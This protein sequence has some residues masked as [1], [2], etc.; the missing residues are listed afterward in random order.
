M[1][2]TASISLTLSIVAFAMLLLVA[3]SPKSPSEKVA[4]ARG[5]YTAK[6]NGFYPKEE[7]APQ[8][9]VEGE[10]VTQGQEKGAQKA[11]QAGAKEAEK[12]SPA[13]AATSTEETGD[14]SADKTLVLDILVSNDSFNTM[15]G[16]TLDISMVDPSGKEIEHRRLWVNTSKVTVGSPVQVSYEL[17]GVPYQKGDGINVEVRKPIP[18]AERSEYREFSDAG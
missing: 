12:G 9:A 14:A 8:G 7:T 2:R 15:P 10:A 16:I 11:P 4:E 5:H 13:A 3:C 18:A 1:K 6:L 17:K